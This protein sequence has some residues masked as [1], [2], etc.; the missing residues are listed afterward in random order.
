MGAL[1]CASHHV[2]A[3]RSLHRLLEFLQNQ[4]ASTKTLRGAGLA[5][6][7][8]LARL[9]ETVRKLYARVQARVKSAQ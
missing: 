3:L 1:C 7:T 6:D 4:G 5:N 2:G 9:I 8:E